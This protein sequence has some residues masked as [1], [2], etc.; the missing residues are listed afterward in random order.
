M[1]ES[2]TLSGREMTAQQ[3]AEAA[4]QEAMQQSAGGASERQSR[5][6]QEAGALADKRLW[7]DER[8]SMD[9]ARLASGGQ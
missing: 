5:G 1:D 6:K 3:E 4:Q 8:A 2:H 9:D 7:P